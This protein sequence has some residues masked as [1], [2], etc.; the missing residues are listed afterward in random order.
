MHIPTL[1]NPARYLGLYIFDFGE[2]TA[3]RLHR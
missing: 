2:W 1:E 3:R